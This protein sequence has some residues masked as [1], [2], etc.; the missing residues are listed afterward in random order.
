MVREMCTNKLLHSARVLV[1]G[2]EEM[3]FTMEL[4]YGYEGSTWNSPITVT[5]TPCPSSG[6]A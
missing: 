4:F 5:G 3:L 6:D 1:F 2:N